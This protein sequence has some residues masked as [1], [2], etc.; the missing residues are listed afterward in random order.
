MRY[1]SIWSFDGE[2]V[3][4]VIEKYQLLRK[5]REENPKKYPKI[6]YPDHSTINSWGGFTVIEG[7]HEQLITL[8]QFWGTMMDF[9]FIPVMEGS[10]VA[11]MQLKSMK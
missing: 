11:E 2:E 3:E 4:K 7:T 8:R 1:L 9:E 10:K 6:L 5:D